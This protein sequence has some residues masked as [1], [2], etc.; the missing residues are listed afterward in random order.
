MEE[1]ITNGAATESSNT[2]EPGTEEK[3]TYTK[4]EVEKLLQQETDRR[5]SAAMRKADAKKAEA[6]KEAQ[7]LAEMSA[8]QKAQYQLEQKERELAEREQR[9]SV[10]E[11]TAEAL[12]VL[13]DKGLRPALV[14]FVVAP[15]AETMMDNI[16]ELEKEFKASVKAEVERRLAG[17]TPKRNLPPDRAIGKEEFARMNLAQQQEIYRNNPELYKQ[18]TGT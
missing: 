12:K 16:N 17:S 2:A 10:A 3:R 8:E 7:R 6:V 13:A 1:T 4:E 14:R 9:L 11:N 5:V 15:D 18:L